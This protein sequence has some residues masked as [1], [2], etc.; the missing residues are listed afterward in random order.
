M[1]N[2]VEYIDSCVENCKC[3]GEITSKSG[4]EFFTRKLCEKLDESGAGG[5]GGGADVLNENGIIKQEH[6]PEGYPYPIEGSAVI[7]PETTAEF[8]DDFGAF[9]LWEGIDASMFTEGES[10]TVNWNGV[11]YA[12]TAVFMSDSGMNAIVLGDMGAAQGTPLSGEPFVIMV[13][14]TASQAGMGVAA[15]IIPIDGSTSIRFSVSSGRTVIPISEKFLPKGY[16]YFAQGGTVL[17]EETTVIPQGLDVPMAFSLNLIEGRNYKVICNGTEYE[18]KCHPLYYQ[19]LFTDFTFLGN[20]HLVEPSYLDNQLPFAIVTAASLTCVFGNSGSMTLAISEADSYMKMD[21]KFSA[22][23]FVDIYG[24]ISSDANGVGEDI[25]KQSHSNPEI[26]SMV[27]QG[28]NV[29]LRYY[30]DGENGP[31]R[32]DCYQ[33][34]TAYANY[35]VFSRIRVSSNTDGRMSSIVVRPNSIR[36]EEFRADSF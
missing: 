4:G 21:S 26:V 8:S 3:N 12:T 9:V 32:Y 7:F 10:Y 36:L 6:L 17:L 22:T 11:D 27:R 18:A 14:D 15:M 29:I 31:Y 5:G 35:A 34:A 19:S 30:V 20:P 13:L 28:K 1:G 33:L 2:Y 16:P 24:T 23:E 25:T